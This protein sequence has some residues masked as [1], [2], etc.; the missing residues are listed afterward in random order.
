[1]SLNY[2]QDALHKELWDGCL[3]YLKSNLGE[4]SFETW[5]RPIKSVKLED[6]LM[7]LR[8]P[9]RYHVEW[10]ES[11]YSEVL[12]A[13]LRNAGYTDIVLDYVVPADSPLAETFNSS[14]EKRRVEKDDKSGLNDQYTFETF[15]EGSSNQFARA[16]AQ[17]VANAP[18]KTSFNP[19]FIYGGVG[20]GKTHLAQA[21]G[22]HA[23]ASGTA[24]RV[25]Y[26]PSEIFTIDFIN[27]LEKGKVESFKK[28]YRSIDLLILDDIQFFINK[29]QTQEQFF[30]TFNALYQ[31]GK[32]IVLTSDTPPR[33]LLGLEAR[34]ISRFQAGLSADVQEPELETRI[35]ILNRM[36]VENHIPISPEIIELFATNIK[37]NIR[38][39]KG[40]LI[41]LLAYASLSSVE[42]DMSLAHRVLKEVLGSSKVQTT[43][44]DIILYTAQ[45]NDVESNAIIG[46]GRQM[47]VAAA[48]Q[49]AMYLAR[50]LTGN[51]LKT[52][53][54]HFGGR[55]H[56][57]V[58]HACK[59]V[60]GRIKEDAEYRD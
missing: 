1:M 49:I 52:I 9:N 35:A 31:D 33:D 30:H 8:M 4:Q 37:G 23:K 44:E 40:S 11:H 59:L 56:S 41:R 60:A 42:I 47:E 55:D 7:T 50:I 13:A 19:L 26:V 48:R 51:S 45:E 21:I 14:M 28:Y 36:A 39:L 43:I 6:G 32:Q 27:S 34:L 12:R 22:N 57:T 38:E 54:L 20:L 17:A 29:E 25:L 2:N 5:F 16:A 46:K 58:I 24:K 18:G 15:V 53:G 3:E 10:I